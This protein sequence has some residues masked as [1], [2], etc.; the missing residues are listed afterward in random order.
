ME[1]IQ[2]MQLSRRLSTP[3]TRHLL[4]LFLLVFLAVPASAQQTSASG[5]VA[6]RVADQAGA[7][8]PGAQVIIRTLNV[9]TNTNPQGEFTLSQV[10]VG[11]HV[12]EVEYLGYRIE[13]QSVTVTAGQRASLT[14]SLVPS[15]AFEDEVTVT[16]SPIRDGQARALNQQ[17]TA[18]NIGNVVSADAIGRFP[19][20]NIAEA[21]Q[22]T[23][24]IGIQRD[25]GEG[26]YINV[27]GAPAEF[28]Q[29]AINGVM[30]PAPDPGTRAMD[31]DT[32]PSDIVN[33]IEVS[34]SLRPDLDADS[35]AGAVNIVTRSPFDASGLRF[36]AS[37]GGSYNDFGGYDTRGSVLVSNLFGANKQFGALASLSYSKTRR[38]VDNVESVW[39]VLDRPEGGEVLGLIENLFK[40]YDTRRE[41]IAG[42]GM[43]EWR[44][45][46]TDRF[47]ING[48]YARFTDDEFRNRLGIIWEDGV[49]LTG[50]T[51]A[52]ASFRNVRVSKQFR[53]RMQRNEVTSVSAGGR[54]FF[55]RGIADYTASFGRADQT[56]PKRNE[57]LYRTGAN[58]TLSYDYSRDPQLPTFSLFETNQ[59]LDLSRY[60]FRENT[61]RS[62]T[63]REDEL[64]FAANI[65]FLG[66]LLG[67]AATHK[68]GV[69]FRGREKTADEERWRDRRA[70]SAPT[71][72]MASLIS[73][74]ASVNYD[75][76]L[77]HKFD[78]DLV[79]AYLS[80]ARPTSEP[81]VPESRTADYEVNEDIYA[82]YGSTNLT[83]GKANL[84][85]GVR[86]EHTS[87]ETFATGYNQ[88]TGQFTPRN[89]TRSYTN[90]F[91]GVTLRYAFSDSLIGRAAVTRAINRPNF[92]EIVPR[93]SEND[94]VTRLRITTGNPDLMPTLATNLDASIEYYTGAIGIL[95]AG[96]FYKDLSDYRFNLTLPGTYN[97][98]PAIITRPENA[99]DGRIAGAEFAWQQQF[100]N[101]PGALSGFG[102]FANYTF[103]S[104]EMNLGRTYEGRS[105]FP[106]TGQSKHTTN[107]GVFY[108]KSGFNARL[109]Y[110]D[111]SDFLTEVNAEDSRLD[112]YWAGRSQVDFT[113]S[114]QMTNLW[115][116][117]LEAK[118]LTNTAGVRYYG[119]SSR[120]Y[121]YEK[122]GYTAF[123]GLR[124]KY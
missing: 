64:S 2:T 21:L 45:T 89:A 42:T 31:L 26:R 47:F 48:S 16:A 114:L 65:E 12:I 53:H 75:Y 94:E 123:L 25:Q 59:H 106:L 69:K 122:F 124:F 101:L 34:K 9:R 97:G 29:V 90:A 108:E 52:S 8:L 119:T 41:R 110:T 68:F 46:P 58:L 20:P 121:E 37:G 49:M 74:T 33:Q 117:Y 38:Q 116:I 85:I 30:L 73:G 36:N 91:P 120:V 83:F 96:V 57:L 95:S 60:S 118:N 32:I 93:L 92:P 27:R 15:T 55:S 86:V 112:L 54:H 3:W 99:P 66:R 115:E 24:G 78:A 4:A 79:N 5:S 103:T 109:S 44:A 61:F 13:T 56:Y 39:D 18:D 100:T 71:T 81:R 19:D 14:F 105:Q 88:N 35:I 7:A 104:A 70:G 80:A 10:P 102:A 76:G 51:D 43:L 23:P 62:N 84:L 113:S 111:R 17:R 87:Q 72:P 40:D 28:S 1:T 98:R 107:G 67:T 6:G 77:G 63:T 50:A 22:R 82:G 11:T